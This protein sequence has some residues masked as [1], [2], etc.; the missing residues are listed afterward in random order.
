[1]TL[2]APLFVPGD[3]PDR[4][5][6]AL[7]TPASAVIIDLEDAVD[8][9]RKD[10]ARGNLVGHG[11]SNKPVFGRLNA[12]DTR[13]WDDDMRAAVEARLAGV[14][15]PKAESIEALYEARAKLRP[16][17][18]II[19]LV[20]TAVG[21][22]RLRDMLMVPGVLCAGFGSLDFGLDLG[23]EPE[24]EPLLY[25][26]S[27]IVLASRLA[28]V[29]APIDGVTPSFDDPERVEADARRARSMGFAGKLLIHPKQIAPVLAAFRPSSQDIEWARRVVEAATSDAAI[30]VDGQMIDKPLVEKA[31]RI[32]SAGHVA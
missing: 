21:L 29:S 9:A 24:W 4:F 25:A 22:S 27:E 30:K 32:L 5:A 19:P 31:R 1:M 23:C 26:R 16:D 10:E 6:K 7:A 17:S 14:L 3:R 8:P 2:L 11:L 15:I 18:H 20:E 28:N 13:W 12:A